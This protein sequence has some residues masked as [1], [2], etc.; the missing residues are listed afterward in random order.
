MLFFTIILF[1]EILF[2][3][4]I[5]RNYKTVDPNFV[6]NANIK[7]YKNRISC[8]VNIKHYI[9]ESIINRFFYPEPIYLD[10]DL[11]KIDQTFKVLNSH[12]SHQQRSPHQCVQLRFL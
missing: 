5:V 10:E 1:A 4:V 2:L 12:Q 6:K 3:N 9:K 11:D 8:Y 7:S